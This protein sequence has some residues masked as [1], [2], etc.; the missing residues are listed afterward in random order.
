MG[1]KKFNDSL[2][3]TKRTTMT[4][5]KSIRFYNDHEVRAV[6]DEENTKW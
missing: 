2:L 6:W 1:I 3:K 4:A 5:K